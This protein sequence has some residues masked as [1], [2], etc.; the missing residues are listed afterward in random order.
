MLD[1]DQAVEECPNQA[2]LGGGESPT[3]STQDANRAVNV[4]KKIFIDPMRL[5]ASY[6]AQSRPFIQ[7]ALRNM[8]N[9]REDE[10]E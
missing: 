3:P 7:N 10:N 2:V 6:M 1:F 8:S 4:R 5:E 9:E